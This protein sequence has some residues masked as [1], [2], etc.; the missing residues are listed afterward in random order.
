M[1]TSGTIE[2]IKCIVVLL[3]SIQKAVS[4][5]A[6]ETL[7]RSEAKDAIKFYIQ[8]HRAILST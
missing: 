2:K 4:K 3:S 1:M 7:A 8:P 6:I 5:Q